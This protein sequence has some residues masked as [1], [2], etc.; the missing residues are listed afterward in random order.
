MHTP[1]AAKL[2]NLARVHQMDFSDEDDYGILD[3]LEDFKL[4]RKGRR[5]KITNVLHKIDDWMEVDMRI[6]DYEYTKGRG[7]SRKR[8]RQTVF[9]VKSKHLGLPE[10]QM[11]PEGLLNKLA[12][13]VGWQQDIDFEEYPKFSGQYLLQGREEDLIR[14]AMTHKVLGFFTKEKR[15]SL[16]TVNYFMILYKK[17][18]ILKPWEVKQLYQ[19]GMKLHHL[20]K[21]NS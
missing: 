21:Y 9:F 5:K 18:R 12:N 4:F 10:M 16:E 20:L 7:V 14:D 13:Y 17:N 8:Q 1:R 2:K 15:W 19:K 3:L 6:F 11:R